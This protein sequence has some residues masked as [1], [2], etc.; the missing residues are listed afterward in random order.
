PATRTRRMTQTSAAPAAAARRT[1]RPTADAAL[2]AEE[3]SHAR[4]EVLRHR[5]RAFLLVAP[6]LV[7]LGFA[8]LAPIGTM[9]FR[10]IYNPGVS[11]LIPQT[12]EVMDDWDGEGLPSDEVRTTFALELRTLFGERRSG[13]LGEEINRVMPGA[14][15]AIQSTG[16]RLSRETED[17]V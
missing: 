1:A 5:L 2:T 10:S 14:S 6:L 13:R 9:L 12:L 7:F 3:K 4:R 17:A 11:G 8:F 15:S 16:R